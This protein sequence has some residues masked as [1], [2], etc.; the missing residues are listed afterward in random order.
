MQGEKQLVN[1]FVV[2]NF[3]H[4]KNNPGAEPE[5]FNLVLQ[6]LA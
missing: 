5:R 3:I 1:G 2:K 6:S 4:Y